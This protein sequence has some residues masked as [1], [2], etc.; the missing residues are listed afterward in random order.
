M[1]AAE[2][3]VDLGASGPYAL[4]QDAAKKSVAGRSAHHG[5]PSPEPLHNALGLYVDHLASQTGETGHRSPA[6]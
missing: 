1:P 3:I 5:T 4:A 6:P 2:K